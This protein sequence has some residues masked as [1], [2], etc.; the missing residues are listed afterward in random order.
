MKKKDL[1]ADLPLR[2]QAVQGCAL[3]PRQVPHPRQPSFG[4]GVNVFVGVAFL[5]FCG[6]SE[7]NL[8]GAQNG[9]SQPSGNQEHTLT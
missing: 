4:Q 1:P 8:S 9:H 5:F 7:N 6:C 3:Y 2:A